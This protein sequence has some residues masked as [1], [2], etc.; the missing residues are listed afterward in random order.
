[1]QI[2]TLALFPF[3]MYFILSKVLAY[4]IQPLSWVFI[5]LAIFFITK[6][7]K[8]KHRCLIAAIV[9]LYIFSNSFLFNKFAGV[10]DIPPYQ[11]K[12][13]D[14]Y[15][16]AIVLGG[17]SGGDKSNHGHF[18]AAADRFIRG[19]QLLTTGKASHLLIT[20]GNGSLDPGTFREGAWAK[21]Q[22]EELGISDS[23]ILIENNS[24]NTIENAKFSNVILQKS[25]LKG[26]YLLVTSGFHM[27]RALMIF[28][29]EGINVIPYSCN[30]MRRDDLS[31]DDYFIPSA[32]PLGGWVFYIKELI[33][34]TVNYF[35]G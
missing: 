32:E 30:L 23:L 18:T 28:K 11:Q 2:I 10:W 26:P 20:G 35:N 17:F 31:F 1:V 3:N 22:L 29:K 15:S 25:N 12:N 8:R 5:L 27:R 16:C 9:I 13:N 6:N 21:V 19:A 7:K 24:K 14:V 33:G 4:F 34:Y